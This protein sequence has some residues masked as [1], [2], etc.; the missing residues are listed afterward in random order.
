MVQRSNREGKERGDNR[1]LKQGE[2]RGK[3]RKKETGK[4]RKGSVEDPGLFSKISERNYLGKYHFSHS[5]HLYTNL[6]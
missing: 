2:L 1:E 6:D 4:C 3:S 5:I